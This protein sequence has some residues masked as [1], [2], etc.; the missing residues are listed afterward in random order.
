[1]SMNQRG[2]ALAP[3]TYGR[4]LYLAALILV[5]ALSVAGN[6]VY[7]YSAAPTGELSLSPGWSAAAHTI[8]PAVLLL[9]T[10][11]LAV[12]S[13]KFSGRGRAWALAG[14]VVVAVSAFVLSFDALRE[15]AIMARVRIELAWLVPIMLDVAI[16]VSTMLVLMASRQ[17]QRDR[18]ALL[19]QE[20][21]EVAGAAVV[22]SAA[23]S[24]QQAE[25]ELAPVADQPAS[26][27]AE[28][29]DSASQPV[30]DQ[31]TSQVAEVADRVR[32]MTGTTKEAEE[33]SRVLELAEE[34]LSQRAISAEVGIDR[35]TIGKWI[36]AAAEIRAE[37]GSVPVAVG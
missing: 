10:E 28:V 33:V 11:V 18:V 1:M 14:V 31:P 29:A 12:A 17:I 23:Q 3:E 2:S 7:A 35:S 30:A 13:T 27:V 15:V 36:K 21:P 34:G 5:V 6:A 22:A 16:V 20:S 26:Q 9:V 4:R 25:P 24:A 8:P 37:A 32:E 19:S